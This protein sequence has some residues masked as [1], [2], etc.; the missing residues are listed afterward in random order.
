MNFS[1]SSKLEHC[2]V[3]QS[4]LVLPNA[5]PVELRLY[6]LRE[7]LARVPVSRSTWFAGI[8]KGRFPKG[9]CLGPRTTVWRSDEIER[10]IAK[11]G[12]TA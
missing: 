8:Q 1:S 11:V 12:E 10:L 3:A 6:R 9:R 5:V 4:E 7:V 2:D